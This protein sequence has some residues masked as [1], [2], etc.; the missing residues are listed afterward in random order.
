ME[1]VQRPH[2]SRG[3]PPRKF[4]H[5]SKN[6]AVKHVWRHTPLCHPKKL[7]LNQKTFF[8]VFAASFVSFLLN[9]RG[10][11]R[12]RHHTR[13]AFRDNDNDNDN[14]LLLESNGRRGTLS[15]GS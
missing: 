2:L 5:K 10:E 8:A 4:T 11:E 1:R 14:G 15:R 12:R 9:R 6:E 3:V 7:V 13:S